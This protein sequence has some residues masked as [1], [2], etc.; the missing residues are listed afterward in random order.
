MN[1]N[2]MNQIWNLIELKEKGLILKKSL[3]GS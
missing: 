3:N 1:R 2:R